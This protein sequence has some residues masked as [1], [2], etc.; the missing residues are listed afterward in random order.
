VFGLVAGVLYANA[1]EWV[2]HKYVLH[3]L[4]KRKG[5]TW[6]FHWVGHHRSSRRNRMVDP[7]Y[8]A[9]FWNW[10][11][12]GKEI[13][14]ILVVVLVHTPLVFWFPYFTLA[15]WYSAFNYLRMHRKAHLDPEWAK[16]HM[17]SHYDHHMGRN[18]DANWCV[19]RPWFDWVMGTREHMEP[20]AAWRALI[21]NLRTFATGA[22]LA[23]GI[24]VAISPADLPRHAPMTELGRGAAASE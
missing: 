19:T 11:A 4:G 7:E 6:A 23:I 20:V 14:G 15:L 13:A 16:R 5:S 21:P 22:T 3:G 2:I 10:N 12:R 17:R 24:A 18:Q 1:I 9:P 8:D